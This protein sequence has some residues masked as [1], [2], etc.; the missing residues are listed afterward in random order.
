MQRSFVIGLFSFVVA[1]TVF[2]FS[3]TFASVPKAVWCGGDKPLLY[4]ETKQ[5]GN[6]PAWVLRVA[7][8]AQLP[9]RYDLSY[10]LNPFFQSGDF[11]GDQ[12]LDVAVLV[13]NKTS[14]TTE[15][16]DVVIFLYGGNP[17]VLKAIDSSGGN[18]TG[19]AMSDYWSVYPQA[20][21]RKSHWEN[22]PPAAKGDALWFAKWRSASAFVFWNGTQYVWYQDTD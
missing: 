6:L 10:H 1:L 4:Q 11:N 14:N 21:L 13:K 16:T 18:R 19:F 3:P 2:W 12:N 5:C 7:N 22:K 15:P 20:E 8:S 9:T 17:Q